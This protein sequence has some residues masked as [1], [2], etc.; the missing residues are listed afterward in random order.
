MDCPWGNKQEGHSSECK[1]TC[2]FFIYEGTFPK[3][4]LAEA[5]K[6]L[7]KAAAKWGIK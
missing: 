4:S 3:C 5:A 7:V 2:A 1:P 6:L